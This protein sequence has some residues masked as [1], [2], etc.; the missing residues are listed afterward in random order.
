MIKE[1]IIAKGT[2]KEDELFEYVNV[3]NQYRTIRTPLYDEDYEEDYDEYNVE[4][5]K[6]DIDISL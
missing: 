4:I 6:D 5:D 2:T 1:D 3:P